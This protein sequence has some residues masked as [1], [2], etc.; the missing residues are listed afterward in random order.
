MRLE[1]TAKN[2]GPTVFATKVR[3]HEIIA[4]LPAEKGGS[5]VAPLPPEIFLAA[6]AECFGMVALI[7]CRD[8]GIPYEGMSVTV[9][10]ENSV[11]DG[12]EH[13]TDMTLHCEFPEE[14][15]KQRLD[16]IMRHTK[17]ACSVRGTITMGAKVEVT[18]ESGNGKA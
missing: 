1:V 6:L 7:H 10:A 14:L 16:A 13:W 2:V 9:S 15:S 18:A 5:D 4:D 8:R 12:Q 17:A 11:D 3:G